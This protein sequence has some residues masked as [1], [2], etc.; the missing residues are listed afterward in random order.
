MS[1]SRARLRLEIAIASS[2]VTSVKVPLDDCTMIQIVTACGGKSSDN[3]F[4]ITLMN[5]WPLEARTTCTSTGFVF[6]A[7]E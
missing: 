4:F 7:H 3:V 1:D 2:F 6:F 5:E